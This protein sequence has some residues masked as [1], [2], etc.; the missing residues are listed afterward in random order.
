MTSKEIRSKMLNGE[1]IEE[2]CQEYQITFPELLRKMS[3][4]G[5]E[6]RYNKNSTFRTGHIYIGKSSSG[7]YVVR[8]SKTY[9]G[10]FNSLDDAVKV[11]DWFI[12]NGWNKRW[13]NRACRLTGVK[14]CQH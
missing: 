11:R 6:K 5:N 12:R 1:T 14:R 2:V 3:K 4:L 9:Y 8:K 13:I 10:S 7:K